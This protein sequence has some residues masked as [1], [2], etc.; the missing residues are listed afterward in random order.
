MVLL[1]FQHY[2]ASIK[3][4]PSLPGMVHSQEKLKPRPNR[5]GD[6]TYGVQLLDIF[7]YDK[8][9]IQSKVFDGANGIPTLSKILL[10]YKFRAGYLLDLLSC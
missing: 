10:K 5:K 6:C 3:I 8:I 1:I 4:G 7:K 2:T 9:D